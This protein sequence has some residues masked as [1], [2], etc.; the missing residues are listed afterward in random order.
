ML[1]EQWRKMTSVG[2]LEESCYLESQVGMY[3]MYTHTQYAF[4]ITL[5]CSKYTWSYTISCT[6]TDWPQLMCFK[7]P[8]QMSGVRWALGLVM[9][10]SVPLHFCLLKWK[11]LLPKYSEL[12]NPSTVAQQDLCHFCSSYVFV[13]IVYAVL[14]KCL[15]NVQSL[16]FL[17]DLV[18][19]GTTEFCISP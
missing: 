12:C 2:S 16:H 18:S 10:G 8:F 5:P 4:S 19:E 7:E 3:G 9:R 14:T 15:T 1:L 17:L 6:F 13:E 11:V